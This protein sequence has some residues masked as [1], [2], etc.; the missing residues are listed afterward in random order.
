M[1]KVYDRDFKLKV[2]KDI[3]NGFETA[4]DIVGKFGISRPIVSRWLTEFGSIRKQDFHQFS[5]W[6]SDS[7]SPGT[8]DQNGVNINHISRISR[9]FRYLSLYGWHMC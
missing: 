2:T 9:L 4:I 3:K 8:Q 5:T 1:R 7:I 6:S